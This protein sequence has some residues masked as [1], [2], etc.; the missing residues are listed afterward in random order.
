LAALGEFADDSSVEISLVCG[1]EASDWQMEA[2]RVA[3]LGFAVWELVTNACRH[4][5]DASGGRV[6]V[7]LARAGSGEWEASVADNGAGFG[8][9]AVCSGE[10]L[11]L[12]IVRSLAQSR[13]GARMSWDY[14]GR[15]S[16]CVLTLAEVS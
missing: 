15:G 14:S 1:E 5:F 4:A 2:S 10:G 3:E 13:L 9:E 8:H 16:R 12:T 7:R 11:G 6:E